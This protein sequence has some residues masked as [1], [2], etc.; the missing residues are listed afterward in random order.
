MY[1]CAIESKLKVFDRWGNL[2]HIGD[3][4]QP[5]N[6]YSNGTPVAQGVYVFIFEY[7]AQD[8]NR[9]MFDEVISGDI[10]VIR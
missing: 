6:G 9:E 7:T 1:G 8:A 5:W 4:L 2:V 3:G 10:T